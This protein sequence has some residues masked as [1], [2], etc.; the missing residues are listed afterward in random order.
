MKSGI[1]NLSMGKALQWTDI[2]T[3]SVDDEN[4][5][6]TNYYDILGINKRKLEVLQNNHE[7]LIKYINAGA[8]IRGG[9]TNTLEFRVMKYYEA[10]NG[11]DG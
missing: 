7:E 6:T 1:Y 11:P 9:F 5:V 10:I 2:A 8:G 3:V 4:E